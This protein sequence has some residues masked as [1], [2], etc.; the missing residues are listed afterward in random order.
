[1]IAILGM[2]ML[3]WPENHKEMMLTYRPDLTPRSDPR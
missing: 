2:E 1:M 3:I